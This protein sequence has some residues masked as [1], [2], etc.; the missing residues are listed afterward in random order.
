MTRKKSSMKNVLLLLLLSGLGLTALVI[1]LACSANPT[2]PNF[3]TPLQTVQ[4]GNPSLTPTVTYTFTMTFTITPTPT[5]SVTPL[6]VLTVSWSDGFGSYNF[7]DPSG[8]AVQNGSSIYVYVADTGN[9]RVEKFTNTGILVTSWGAGGKGKGTISFPTP[10]AV[11]VNSNGMLYVAGPS[12]IGVFDANGNY[13]TTYINPGTGS[14]SN[15]QGLALD[16]SGNLYIS[17]SGNNRIVELSNNGTP[18][19]YGSSGGVT[20]AT[21]NPSGLTVDTSDNVYVAL[22]NN[23]IEGFNSSGVSFITINGFNSPDG[24][25]MDSSNDLF[26]ADT[27]NKT[28]EEFPGSPSF[29]SP[30]VFINPNNVLNVPRGV[31]VDSTGEIYVVDSGNNGN[32]FRGTVYNFAP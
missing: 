1:G 25:A 24:L 16:G 23:T 20:I 22:N 13:L 32:S 27:G 5:F 17:D 4:A 29:I 2:G 19:S 10:Q 26:V 7:K 9:G 30:T 21:L 15:P 11:A 31:A 18:E 8:I 28:I 3:Q 6:P 14:F 12:G